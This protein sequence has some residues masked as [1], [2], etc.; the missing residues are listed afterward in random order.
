VQVDPIKFILK[1]PRTKLL[2]LKY[3]V[4]LLNFAF[5]FNLRRYTKGG[6]FRM[7]YG[8]SGTCTDC[9]FKS[10]SGSSFVTHAAAGVCTRCRF[11]SNSVG[12]C[13]LSIS[14]RKRLAL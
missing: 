11:V 12:R 10:N 13:M 7:V 1:A 2:K 5:K 3:D 9:D 4:P 6:A 8:S 14:K